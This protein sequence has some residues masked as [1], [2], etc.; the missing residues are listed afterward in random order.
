[1]KETLFYLFSRSIAIFRTIVFWFLI[2]LSTVICAQEKK[3]NTPEP[4]KVSREGAAQ[5]EIPVEV[6]RALATMTKNQQPKFYGAY[7]AGFTVFKRHK[8]DWFMLKNDNETVDSQVN[9]VFIGSLASVRSLEKGE[10]YQSLISEMSIDCKTKQSLIRYLDYK[11]GEF[12]T[13]ESV[14][15]VRLGSTVNPDRLKR[16]FKNKSLQEFVYSSACN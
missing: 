1:M 3:E 10:T 8:Q 15:T 11:Q 14:W 16:S 4:S 9:V 2:G 13:G 6:A 5:D 12:G 7:K